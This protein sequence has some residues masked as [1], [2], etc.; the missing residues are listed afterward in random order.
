M[1]VRSFLVE[2]PIEI[3][4]DRREAIDRTGERGPRGHAGFG[5]N[6]RHHGERV[7]DR[8][9]HDHQAGAYQ[10]GVRNADRVHIRR[11]QLLHQPHHVVAEIAEQ[12]GGHGRQALG[13]LDAA[14][15]E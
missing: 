1:A 15:G 11:R 4:D 12:A 7:L 5:P 10:N 6:R 13:K 3:V 8:I 14:L 9:E 2:R